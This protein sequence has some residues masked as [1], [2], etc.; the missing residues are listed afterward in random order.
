[1]L[2]PPDTPSQ[3]KARQGRLITLVFTI[4]TLSGNVDLPLNNLPRRSSNRIP[5]LDRVFKVE[6]IL[7]V[8]CKVLG[9]VFPL[10]HGQIGNLAL[11][12][13]GKSDGSAGNVMGL[14][15]WNLVISLASIQVN[16]DERTPLRTR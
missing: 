14:T 3:G 16:H 2:A 5:L 7:D 8:F 12:L 1:M 13:F 9:E 11:E 10:V 15:E 6:H 4:D